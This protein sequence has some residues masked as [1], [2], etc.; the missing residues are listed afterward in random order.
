[1]NGI[2]H[3]LIGQTV[4]NRLARSPID[5][6]QSPRRLFLIPDGTRADKRRLSRVPK[7]VPAT[8][9][10]G[11]QID[12][13]SGLPGSF[14][15]EGPGRRWVNLQ[16]AGKKAGG[17]RWASPTPDRYSD[18]ELSE[19]F[20]HRFCSLGSGHVCGEA[21]SSAQRAPCTAHQTDATCGS[22]RT[23][24]RRLPVG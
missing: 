3:A 23:G 7:Q 11:W 15:G 12:A 18:H 21:D 9:I 10:D 5:R 22:S 1:M 19:R 8:G 6:L 13:M 2:R 24:R 17:R 16:Q 20:S 14:H 4:P